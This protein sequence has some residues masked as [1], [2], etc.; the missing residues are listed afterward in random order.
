MSDKVVANRN[1]GPAVDTLIA[2]AGRALAAGDPL[3]ALQ[4]IA[5]REDAPALALRG[6][7]MA[8]L[9]DFERAKPLLRRA[10]RAFGARNGVA[11]ARC[12]VAEAE[13]AL[14]AR[15]LKRN[16]TTLAEA[17]EVLHAHGDRA[18]AAHA[19][20]LEARFLLLVGRIDA[21]EQ[22]LL[23]LDPKPLPLVLQAIHAL[24]MAGIAMRRIDARFARTALARA[25]RCARKAG[26]P[27]LIAEIEAATRALAAPVAR[28]LARD[29]DRP[30]ALGGVEALL[31]SRALVV[32]AC[33]YV[34]SHD[35]TVVALAK[36]PLLFSLA[37]ALAEAWPAGAP[38]ETLIQRA[39]RLKPD[40]TLRARL[41]VEIGRLRATLR[42]IADVRATPDGFALL[43]RNAHEVAVL[44]RPLEGKHA[45]ILALL[46][47]GE[48]WSSSAIAL[49]LGTSQRNVQR[50]LGALAAEGKV[51]S[52]GRG[53]VR[54]WLTPPLPGFTTALLLPA[55]FATN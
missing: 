20:L 11:R 3:A 31:A 13:I 47:D 4:G 52:F 34:V 36:R 15:D 6:I 53:R 49:V 42:P 1:L 38:R 39:F 33:R 29:H 43:P 10:A 14:A 27:A 35:G 9:G 7:A 23:Q 16:P 55:P 25:G 22:A 40:A 17:R 48:T 24:A 12:A 8:Q 45:A 46:A 41:R 26:V 32:D 44:A 37:R 30:I 50:A 18:N 51:Q 19:Q 21:A 54:R 5:L 2:N 28:L